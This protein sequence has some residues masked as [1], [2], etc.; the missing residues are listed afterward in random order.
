MLYVLIDRFND[1]QINN[2]SEISSSKLFLPKTWFKNIKCKQKNIFYQY[3]LSLVDHP[4]NWT[5][6]CFTHKYK[7]LSSDLTKTYL[8]KRYIFQLD[9]V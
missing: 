8:K 2:I 7:L 9:L 4:Y 1:K 3:F 5:Y 6:L